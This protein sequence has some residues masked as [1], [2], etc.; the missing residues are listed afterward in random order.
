MKVKIL[1]RRNSRDRDL[2]SSALVIEEC[3][4]DWYEL[5]QSFLKACYLKQDLVV[6]DYTFS[7]VPPTQVWQSLIVIAEYCSHTGKSL[8]RN[9]L[10]QQL[11]ITDTSLQSGFKAL[12]SLG[13]KVIYRDRAFYFIPTETSSS[14]DNSIERFLTAVSEEQLQRQYF[15]EV[16]IQVIKSTII[17][18]LMLEVE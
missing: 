6:L 2:L 3:P 15:C 12:N 8:S 1:D 9:E 18:N 16:S 10:R 17:E 4:T 5:Q 14:H 11:G 7:P 13:F